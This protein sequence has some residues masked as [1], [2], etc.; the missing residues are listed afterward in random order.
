MQ[1]SE[2]YLF[3]CG[4]GRLSGSKKENDLIWFDLALAPAVKMIQLLDMIR[5]CNRLDVKILHPTIR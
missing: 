4:S 1:N 3:E 5:L 2:I